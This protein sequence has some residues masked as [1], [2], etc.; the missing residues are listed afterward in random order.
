MKLDWGLLPPADPT[1]TR[2]T[3]GLELGAAVRHYNEVAVPGLGG[4]WFAKPLIWSL[5]GVRIAR[6][7]GKPPIAVANAIEALAC[8]QEIRNGQ[9]RDPRLRGTQKLANVGWDFVA[10]G[11]ASQRAFYVTQPMRQ[12]MTQPL[13]ELGLVESSSLRFNAYR[14]SSAG[15]RLLEAALAPFRPFNTSVTELVKEWVSGRGTKRRVHT[16]ELQRALSPRLPLEPLAC[17]VLRDRLVAG[18]ENAVGS[19]RRRAALQWVST[20]DKPPG[21]S[22]SDRPRSIS[23]PHWADLHTGGRFFQ[24]RDRGL[25]LLDQAE[26]ALQGL[27]PRRLTIA[28]LA[29]AV[30]ATQ[31]QEAARAVLERPEGTLHPDAKRFCGE[32]VQ[33]PADLLA[34]L[35]GRDGKGLKLAGDSI[36]AGAAFRGGDPTTNEV[37]AEDT[38]AAAPTRLQLPEGISGRVRNLWT[39]HLDL[40]GR[41]AQLLSP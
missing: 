8:W 27:N 23:K 16:W 21:S 6:A 10:Y 11:R 19:R 30:D 18:P 37:G 7:L 20:F 9:G 36:V 3:R 24:A 15:E 5:L 4:L 14:P 2:R 1:S 25:E 17:A 22:W 40:D 26:A 33:P 34:S 31:L 32:A 13:L 28:K 38:G 12:A 29:S 39:L 41:L 35:V